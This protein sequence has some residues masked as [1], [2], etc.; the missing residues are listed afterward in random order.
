MSFL[1]RSFDSY[2]ERNELF[3]EKPSI[4]LTPSDIQLVIQA[5]EGDKV[6]FDLI[7]AR[8]YNRI[9]RFQSHMVGDSW[10]G[11][12][13]A[14]ETFLKAW[15]A[16]NALRDPTKF[17][18][19]LYRIAVNEVFTYYRHLNSYSR[20]FYDEKLEDTE[21][22]IPG[23][24]N[25]VETKEQLELVLALVSPEKC[26]ACFILYHI[27]NYSIAQVAEF[28]GIKQSSV[29]QYASSGLN[30]FKRLWKD[31]NTSKEDR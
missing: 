6:A 9:Y 17:S 26:R 4:I 18:S 13:L 25:L 2:D 7:C 28:L 20:R 1:R 14:Q 3:S 21:M 24:E 16:L 12:D 29:R 31:V 19:W 8:F 5:Q 27:E 30:Q 23:P 10:I 22:S 15:R 11:E